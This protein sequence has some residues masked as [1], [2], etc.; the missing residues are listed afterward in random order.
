MGLA[1]IDQLGQQLKAGNG[2]KLK[3]IE[4]HDRKNPY[5]FLGTVL[6]KKVGVGV[7]D[8]KCLK[9]LSATF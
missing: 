2:S 4:T 8:N 5:V 3:E 9:R 7:G 1:M 6:G